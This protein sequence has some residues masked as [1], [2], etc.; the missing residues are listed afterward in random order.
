[1]MR[2]VALALLLISIAF[3]LF[4]AP[5]ADSLWIEALRSGPGLINVLNF[6]SNAYHPWFLEPLI[7]KAA[8]GSRELLSAIYLLI[9]SVGVILLALKLNS[10]SLLD[11][12]LLASSL[13]LCLLLIFGVDLVL[14]SALSIFPIYLWALLSAKE[15]KYLTFGLL[16]SLLLARQATILTPLL[17]LIA[18]IFHQLHSSKNYSYKTV[19]ILLAP[20]LT[21]WLTLPEQQHFNYPWLASLVP[22]DGLA[23]RVRPLLGPETELP[24]V[25]RPELKTLLLP[26]AL[27]FSCFSFF[28]YRRFS[29][30]STLV[31][32]TLSLCLLCD[33]SVLPESFSQISP[34]ATIARV[35]PGLFLLPLAFPALGFCILFY[36]LA[37]SHS[38]LSLTRST[39]A[40]FAPLA[41]LLAVNKFEPFI[42]INKAALAPLSNL[43]ADTHSTLIT[44]SYFLYRHPDLLSRLNFESIESLDLIESVHVSHNNDSAALMFD[45]LKRT[46]WANPIGAQ[47]GDEWIVLCFKELFEFQGLE[48]CLGEFKTDFPRAMNLYASKDLV[49]TLSE[50]K[51][52]ASLIAQRDSWFGPVRM[53][54]KNLPYFGPE[55]DISLTLAK[56][57]QLRCL[58]I[59][60][61]GKS[62]NFDWSVAELRLL[63]EIRR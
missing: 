39:V 55:L 11:A 33:S 19:L 52:N 34:L 60:Q 25:N 4:N 22:D 18:L 58:G 31:A 27:I 59:E 45:K 48:L 49:S 42:M 28:L 26:A 47:R 23:G 29:S 62:K 13:V 50:L 40:I 44:P 1:M 51:T 12:L 30:T 9:F 2:I 61:T 35:L 5:S 24:F 38:K 17:V 14:F 53:N 54:E 16:I 46:R 36:I 41:L 8:L 57:E 15:P 7:F 63:R 43:N 20:L 32:L 3:A 56:P 10:A 6:S 21:A 37:I